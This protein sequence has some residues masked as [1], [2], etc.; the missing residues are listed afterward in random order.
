M[1][2]LLLL[3]ELFLSAGSL[4]TT[5]AQS[6]EYFPC[7]HFLLC[8]SSRLGWAPA[9]TLL[10]ITRQFRGNDQQPH[11]QRRLHSFS[12]ENNAVVNLQPLRGCQ[13][14]KLLLH[15]FL[16][17]AAAF[18]SPSLHSAPC[19][20]RTDAVLALTKN[21]R[22]QLCW[23]TLT[24]KDWLWFSSGCFLPGLARKKN[25]AANKWKL[26]QPL[27]LRRRRFLLLK[28]LLHKNDN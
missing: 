23:P 22:K 6:A 5:L 9:A 1:V 11:T 19:F 8:A 18:L 17:D 26:S 7:F 10:I 21:A 15:E 25:T 14:A 2:C 3:R 20:L 16:L 13:T 24:M 28:T 4:K 12:L 27:L